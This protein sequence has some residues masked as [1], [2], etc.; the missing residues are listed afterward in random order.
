MIT[1]DEAT[2]LME[3]YIF[4]QQRFLDPEFPV[5]E[6]ELVIV[7]EAVIERSYGWVFSYQP[8]KFLET[9][10]IQYSILGNSPV[11]IKK[12]DGS[13]YNLGT[14]RSIESALRDYE[15]GKDAD[16]IRVC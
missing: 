11:L 8:K 5:I 16:S 13:M 10:E 4:E 6:N 14:H 3:D 9:G 12:E 7:P 2:K 15:S 1:F